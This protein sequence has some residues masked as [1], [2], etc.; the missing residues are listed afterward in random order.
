VPAKSVAVAYRRTVFDAVGLF[1]ESFDACEDVEFNHRVDR[2][3]LRCYFTPEVAVRYRP[4]D[5][6]RG[7]FYQLLRYGRGRMRLLRKHPDTLSPATLVPLI[8]VIGLIGG[9][10][11]A[12]THPLLG[13]IYVAGIFAYA[14]IILVGA[15]GIG[16]RRR[17]LQL[18][19][20]LVAVFAAIHLG[21]GIGMLMET[22]HSRHPTV[23]REGSAL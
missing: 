19:P 11:L 16:A 18:L 15:F 10:P 2:A 14:S 21:S 8:F 20:Q 12:L 9:L 3:G 13:T 5:T 22:L 23:H 4:R 1:D 7:L 6:L 17:S